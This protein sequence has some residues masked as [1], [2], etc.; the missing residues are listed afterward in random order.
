MK[1]LEMG[2]MAQTLLDIYARTWQSILSCVNKG[3]YHQHN[4]K[5]YTI[6]SFVWSFLGGGQRV[7]GV[8]GKSVRFEPSILNILAKEMFYQ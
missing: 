4:G 5:I 3:L 6:M 7:A 8:G 2:R 1:F